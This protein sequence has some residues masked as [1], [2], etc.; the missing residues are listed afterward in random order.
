MGLLKRI[1]PTILE[2]KIT[3]NCKKST[4]DRI[5]H[6][7]IPVA[8]KH[9]RDNNKQRKW[10]FIENMNF[11]QGAVLMLHEMS[12]WHFI[13]IILSNSKTLYGL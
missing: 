4:K 13:Q 11:I 6:F 9:H 2:R 1:F 12:T 3:T 5:T 10:T 8:I 7:N